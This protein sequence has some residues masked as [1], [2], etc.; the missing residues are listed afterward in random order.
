MSDVDIQRVSALLEIA[1][2]CSGHSGK[3]SNLQSWAIGELMAINAQ[4]K[5]EAVA[6]AKRVEADWQ[7]RRTAEIEAAAPIQPA[8]SQPADDEP[9]TDGDAIPRRI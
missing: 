8:T 7:R 3:L 5:D 1:E 2:R 6:K 4:I 9:T